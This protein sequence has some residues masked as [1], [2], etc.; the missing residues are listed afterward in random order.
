M[1]IGD[2]I[3][4]SPSSVFPSENQIVRKLLESPE[5]FGQ[6]SLW[7]RCHRVAD[8]IVCHHA[9][10]RRPRLRLPAADA[11]G[12]ASSVGCRRAPRSTIDG[13]QAWSGRRTPT[14]IRPSHTISG[15]RAGR[16]RTD[17]E[18]RPRLSPNRQTARC[19]GAASR[20]CPPP[21]PSASGE[22]WQPPHLTA[23]PPR[24]YRLDPR[25]Q[26]G[27]TSATP[28]VVRE[29]FGGLRRQAVRPWPT[30]SSRAARIPVEPSSPT[31]H[32]EHAF[33]PVPHSGA[34]RGSSRNRTEARS[35]RAREI[36]RTDACDTNI[37]VL[38]VDS[39]A[40][41]FMYVCRCRLLPVH[42]ER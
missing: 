9:Y 14:G 36:C 17:D 40:T 12:R 24:S 13:S 8:I 3:E 35:R 7:P 25:A 37:A 4:A 42:L 26:A 15:D 31:H 6:P 32:R 33:R 41:L 19:S 27:E 11:Y 18:A 30:T 39:R 5:Q 20:H 21:I 22:S 28:R 2:A 16:S 10:W 23:R 38:L 1:D 29:R 34:G